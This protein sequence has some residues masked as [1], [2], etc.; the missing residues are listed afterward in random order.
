MTTEEKQESPFGEVTL[1]ASIPGLPFSQMHVQVKAGFNPFTAASAFKARFIETFGAEAVEAALA[2]AKPA[3]GAPV[4]S[5]APSGSAPV[6]NLHNKP[7]KESRKPGSWFCP[8]KLA[9]GSYCTEKV[10]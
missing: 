9:D 6:C 3:Q 10:G 8:A 2:V 1:S 7:M 4:A 5:A